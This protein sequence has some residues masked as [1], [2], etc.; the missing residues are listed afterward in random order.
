MSE[1]IVRG[2]LGNQLFIILEAYRILLS[3]GRSVQLNLSEYVVGTRSDRQFVAGM[4]L[5]QVLIDFQISK[6]SYAYIKYIYAKLSARFINRNVSC[7]R[8]PGDAACSF[9]TH[10]GQR[11]YIGYF[12]HIGST[13]M[14]ASALS[15][16]KEMFIQTISNNYSNR[17]AIHVRRGDYI[18]AKHSMHGIISLGDLLAESK[19]ALHL[20]NFEGITVFTDS[21]ELL[22]IAEFGSLGVDVMIDKG[23]QP[24]DV[25]RRMASHAGIIASNSSFSL[26]AGLLGNPRYFSLP[27]FWMPSVESSRLGLNY[28]RRYPCTLQ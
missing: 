15:R 3:T 16:M 26:W 17:L 28:V 21:P 6:G 1:F 11:V 23:G 5:P 13:P 10:T 20:E 8:L 4:F 24:G 19:R 2:G 7:S 22:D 14:G 25:L 9:L 27:Q 18:L 12:Q